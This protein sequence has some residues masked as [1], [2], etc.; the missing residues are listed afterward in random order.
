MST[1]SKTVGPR[2]RGLYGLLAGGLL[3][4]VAATV[5]ALPVAD[6]QPAPNAIRPWVNPSTQYLNGI[7]TSTSS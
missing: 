5:I 6:S 7:P 1:T 2:R 4:A 3:A